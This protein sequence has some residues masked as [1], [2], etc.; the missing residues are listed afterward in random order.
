MTVLRQRYDSN[1]I[2]NRTWVWFIIFRSVS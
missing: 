1:C 2:T